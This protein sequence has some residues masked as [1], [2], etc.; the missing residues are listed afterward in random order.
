MSAIGISGGSAPYKR[1]PVL[2]SAHAEYRPEDFYFARTQ[3]PA[4]RALEWEK[5]IRPMHS[6]S[7]LGFYAAGILAFMVIA[8]SFA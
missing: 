7:E 3:S 8:V 6:W 1:R 4:L 2:I 5:R